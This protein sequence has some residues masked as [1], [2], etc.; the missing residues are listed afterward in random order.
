MMA[1][2]PN[3]VEINPVAPDRKM[4]MLKSAFFLFGPILLRHGANAPETIG[5][6][7]MFAL[8]AQDTVLGQFFHQLRLRDSNHSLGSHIRDGSVNPMRML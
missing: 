5:V 2:D 7:P 6:F 3:V 1:A 4:Y 8:L